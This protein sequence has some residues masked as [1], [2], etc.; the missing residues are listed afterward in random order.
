MPA[1]TPKIRYQNWALLLMEGQCLALETEKTTLM[2]SY[3]G[4]VLS[5]PYG[6]KKVDELIEKPLNWVA[7]EVHGFL[8]GAKS[9]EHFLDLIDMVR[10][11]VQCQFCQRY[12]AVAVKMDQHWWFRRGKI[13]FS[14]SKVNFGWGKAAFGSYYF[15]WGGNAGCVMSLPST[16]DNGDWVVYM[17][18]S[19]GEL[20]LIE[21]EAGH[22][23]KPLI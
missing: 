5:I 3:F 21:C 2:S 18:L 12:I 1:V 8:E 23:F 20:E 15:P 6:T 9:R 11:I 13:K 4:N 14:V 10:P 19:E 22:V 16:S 7:N 17:H